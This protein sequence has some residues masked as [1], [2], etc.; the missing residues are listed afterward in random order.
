MAST[1]FAVFLQPGSVER[2]LQ[3]PVSYSFRRIPESVDPTGT[4]IWSLYKEVTWNWQTI[5]DAELSNIKSA[6]QADGTITF[7]T[8]NDNGAMV[9]CVGKTDRYPAVARYRGQVVDF[10]IT[11]S[12]VVEV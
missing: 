2:I 10:S 5:T 11:F 7:R 4:T 12:L 8:E 9:Q 3:P 6:I 1:D